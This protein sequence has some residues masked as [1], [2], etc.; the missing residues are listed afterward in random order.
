MEYRKHIDNTPELAQW[1]DE[2]Y[3][4]MG[5]CWVTP[6]NECNQHLDRLGV[7]NNHFLQLLDVGC[8]GGYFLAEAEKRVSCLGSEVS[9][10]ALDECRKRIDSPVSDLSIEDPGW[11]DYD[12]D[13]IVSIGSLEHI[14]DLDKALDNI[15]YMLSGS[16][17]G[18]WYF[19]C[20]NEL[21]TH[22]DQ[23]NE[24]TMTDEE[25]VALFSKHDLVTEGQE[26]LNDN[27]AFWGGVR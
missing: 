26:R 9:A 19:Y 8:G 2:K 20:P 5:G 16:P 12:F 17:V 27:T 18:K 24:R 15:H 4:E 3:R 11:Q 25:W 13:Y 1:Y 10:E 21:W 6:A 23:P 7:R 14:V 22:E